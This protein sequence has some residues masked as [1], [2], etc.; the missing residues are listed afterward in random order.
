MKQR[1]MKIIYP[2]FLAILIAFSLTGCN[3]TEDFVPDFKLEN[4]IKVNSDL[5][6]TATLV[7]NF[8]EYYY[9]VDE[10][11]HM[12]NDEVL[13]FNEKTGTESMTAEN[14]L[15][16]EEIVNAVLKFADREAYA[17]YNEAVFFVGTIEEALNSGLRLNQILHDINDEEKTIDKDDLDAMK[18]YFILI[19]NEH[20]EIGPL[21]V[22]VFGRISYVS[23]G[24]A[25]WHGRNSVMILDVSD[26]LIYILF[27]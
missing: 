19:T 24:I 11:Y 21:S 14:V 12:I 16:E 9:N 23:N 17:L 7:D 26:E 8:S 27:K 13:A 1:K 22:E 2:A 4:A 5:S 20:R 10:L 6:I 15:V 25:A 18:D 3:K